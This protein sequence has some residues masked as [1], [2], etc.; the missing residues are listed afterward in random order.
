MFPIHAINSTT[1]ICS[2]LIVL[3]SNI[4]FAHVNQGKG[5]SWSSDGVIAKS[6]CPKNEEERE[7]NLSFYLSIIVGN[8]FLDY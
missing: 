4:S 3:M 8:W 2:I 6:K 7:V 1:C 5:P